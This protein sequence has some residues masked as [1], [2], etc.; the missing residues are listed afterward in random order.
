MRAFLTPYSGKR[1][2]RYALLMAQHYEKSVAAWAEYCTRFR[3]DP[4]RCKG[5]RYP[6]FEMIV[7]DDGLVADVRAEIERSLVHKSANCA[8]DS[9]DNEPQ[10]PGAVGSGRAQDGL[11]ID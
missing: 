6:G 10:R 4:A 7:M 11:P 9:P 2:E 3:I 1:G 5:M 8:S